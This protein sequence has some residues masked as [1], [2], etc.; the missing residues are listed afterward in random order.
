MS[1]W[2]IWS[3]QEFSENQVFFH[4]IPIEHLN[5]CCPL[6]M[7]YLGLSPGWRF[8]VANDGYED[9]WKDDSLLF[10]LMLLHHLQFRNNHNM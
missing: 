7:K 3:G 4:P 1:V 5:E 10:F 8:V 9:V 6:L 2:Y